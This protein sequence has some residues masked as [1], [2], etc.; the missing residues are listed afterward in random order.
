VQEAAASES[1][2]QRRRSTRIIRSIPLTV[3]G[4]DLLS[5]P[6]EERTAT[7]ALNTYGCKYPSKHHLPKNTWI[8][9]EIPAPE[10]ADGPHRVR[11]R[12]VWIQRPRSV[13]EMFQIAVEL[14][15][16]GNI[17]SLPTPPVDWENAAPAAADRTPNDAV[18]GWLHPETTPRA[19]AERYPAR[20][21]R[22][23]TETPLTDHMDEKV[24]IATNEEKTPASAEAFGFAGTVVPEAAVAGSLDSP[25]LRELRG[26][27]ES[28]ASR[29]AEDAVAQASE[30]LKRTVETVEREHIA[31][32][33]AFFQR[34]RDDF[35]R[36]RDSAREE[37]SKRA[38]EQMA[39]VQDEISAGV[40]GQMSW[41]REELRADLR[42]EF[43]SHI[44]QM[45][46]LV[47]DLERG[48]QA[49]RE[50]S[51]A[52]TS[53]GDR[54]AQIKIA[55]ESAEAAVDQRMRRLK[56]AAQETVALDDLSKAWREK[57]QEQMG[58]ARSEW[59]ELLQS[60]LD[61]AAQ[62][63]ASRLGENSQSV[64]ESAE[65]K[66]AERIGQLCEP[67]TNTVS[68]AH[69]ALSGIRSALDTEL[70]RARASLVDI[71][72]AA[73]RMREFSAQIDAASHDAL[74]QL[75]QRLDSAL[76][77]QVTELRRHADALT[78]ELPQRIQPAL[79]AAGQQLVS[80]TLAEIDARLAPHL[81]RVPE[82]VRELTAHEVQAEEGLR[83]YRERLRQAAESSQR[84][85]GA[86]M[87]A[88]LSA[89][90]SEFE[91]ARA[92]ALT[93]WNEELES[94]GARAS[95]AVIEDLVKNAEW[96]QKQ[97]QAYIETL[98][99][100]SLAKT[101]GVF[102]ARTQEISDRLGEQ[103][104]QQNLAH[105]DE[106]KRQLDGR[107]SEVVERTESQLESASNAMA[108]AFEE[109]IRQVAESAVQRF[110][111][112]SD[113]SI[114]ERTHQIERGADGMRMN[115]EHAAGTLLERH[116]TEMA[117]Y[118]EQKF[119]EVRD[120]HSRELAAAVEAARIERDDQVR[121]WYQRLAHAN[122]ESLQKYEDQ[123]HGASELWVN[124]AV[125]KL[126]DSGQAALASLT[127]SG[128]QA[129]RN[130]LLKALE[131]VTESV[132]Q[133]IADPP[134]SGGGSTPRPTLVNPSGPRENRAGI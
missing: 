118:G 33:E 75:H 88:T 93:R 124:V 14:E 98:T 82:L 34:W 64:L 30:T 91:N 65:S 62:R 37:I 109:G 67:V 105:L 101:E 5:Q 95:H 81:E 4:V 133:S 22:P 46:A 54:L 63:L 123:L 134:V 128:E 112:S 92:E 113:A 48:A 32:A 15:T 21:D 6:F 52:A 16:P 68:E 2:A 108:S 127:R 102:Q 17:W 110:N 49:V 103:L 106:A 51:Q 56:D 104:A 3:R 90:R 42:Q 9:L 7:V 1:Q 55:L 19:Q 89:L 59:N 87:S 45:R 86:Q 71:E 8:T 44:D 126:N 20:D 115:F 132:R 13:R 83:M 66:L 74:N 35:D 79:D 125:D 120:F 96:H 76:Q 25:L 58:Q 12:V 57:L 18:T 111:E 61:G 131:Q 129:L 116:R 70:Q 47:A 41:V 85:T 80:K 10:D 77:S 24:E 27:I 117:A 84:D 122:E 100:E 40:T 107:S 78:S 50:E 72:G 119:A 121:D 23:E 94:S 39:S 11:A 26:H 31:S 69:R 97:A 99:Q 36:E 38:S 28:Q 29:A 73:E 43:A 130:S 60:S 114:T 53:S